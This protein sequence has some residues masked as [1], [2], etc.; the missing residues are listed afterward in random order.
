[1]AQSEHK[2][3][4][5]EQKGENWRSSC[6]VQFRTFTLEALLDDSPQEASAVVAEGGT[7]VVVGLEAVR[8]VDLEALLLELRGQGWWVGTLTLTGV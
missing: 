5:E 8:H 7:H 1:M 2:V 3:R 4:S 6:C